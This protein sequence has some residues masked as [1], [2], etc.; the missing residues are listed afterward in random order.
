MFY[1]FSHS[2]I[3]SDPTMLCL[4][5]DADEKWNNDFYFVQGA[6]C[7]FGMMASFEPD[8][9]PETSKWDEEIRLANLAV[10]KVN[11]LNPKPRF[12]IIC[13]DLTHQMPSKH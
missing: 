7:Q 5:T 9:K 10:Q 8:Y 11:Q 1:L 2:F 3:V 12:F 4:G 6:D 13:G